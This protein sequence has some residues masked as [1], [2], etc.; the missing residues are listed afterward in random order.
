MARTPLFLCYMLSSVGLQRL[1]SELVS[2][3]QNPSSTFHTCFVSIGYASRRGVATVVFRSG[4]DLLRTFGFSI[5]VGA[6]FSFSCSLGCVRCNVLA[7]LMSIP[8]SETL[9]DNFW[10]IQKLRWDCILV[11]F[12]IRCLWN[13]QDLKASSSRSYVRRKILP[14]DGVSWF[15]LR[16]NKSVEKWYLCLNLEGGK[17][18]GCCSTFE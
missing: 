3:S 5:L 10:W 13:D 9:I 15:S 4:L 8:W 1:F 7:V 18:I 17:S 11:V 16:I 14:V 6:C 12:F 2:S